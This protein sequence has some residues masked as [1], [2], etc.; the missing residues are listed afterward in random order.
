MREGLLA[1]YPR[2]SA[3]EEL[4]GI[5]TSL[6]GPMGD[7]MMMVVSVTSSETSEEEAAPVVVSSTASENILT[8]AMPSADARTNCAGG[9]V[10]DWCVGRM[11]GE[12]Q[13]ES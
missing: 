2:W 5:C 13:E 9:T 4:P 3:P 6:D 8:V 7:L 1:G 11:E 10:E 12:G